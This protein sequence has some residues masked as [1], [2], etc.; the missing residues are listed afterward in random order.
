MSIGE[1]YEKWEEKKGANVTEKKDKGRKK[2][3]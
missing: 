1:K 2:E 3:N